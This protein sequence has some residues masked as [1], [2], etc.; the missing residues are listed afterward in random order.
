MRLM[1]NIL[2]IILFVLAL[3]SALGQSVFHETFDQ[4]S[5][6][7]SENVFDIYKDSKGYIWCTTDEGL[8]RFN[9]KQFIAFE[10]PENL[11]LAGSNIKEDVFGRIWYQTFDG[12]FLYVSNNQLH[13]LPFLETS[14][15]KPY[16]IN[17]TH[18]FC[19][20]DKG[21]E[22]I[23]LK[24]L[25]PTL[26]I[27]G[28]GFEYCHLLNGTI[29]YGN[30]TIRQYNLKTK[31]EDLLLV[32]DA[33][34][35]SLITFS[36]NGQ[37]ILADRNNSRV[38]LIRI[39]A[40]GNIHKHQLT[41][42][43]TIQNL[44]VLE[45][46]HWIFTTNGIY[47]FDHTFQPSTNCHFLKD[48]NV[49]SFTKDKNDHLWVGSPNKG[50]F[51][52]KDLHSYEATLKDD[53]FSSL[54][55]KEGIVYTGTK[56]GKIYNH[57]KD[58]SP[59]LYYS[60][61]ENNHILFMDFNSYSDWNFFTGNGLYIM[62]HRTGKV[63]EN[64]ISVK[65]ICKIDEH[66]LG[67]SAT[68]FTGQAS[69]MDLIYNK[70]LQLKAI[71][72]LRAKSCAY[73]PINNELYSA[74]NKG[75]FCITSSHQNKRILFQQQNLLAKDLVYFNGKIIGVTNSGQLFS[76][77]NQRVTL[78]NRAIQIQGIKI[79]GNTCFLSSK[80][81]IYSM[82]DHQLIKLN[83]LNKSDRI[84]DFEIIGNHIY[85]LTNQK[86]IR[87]RMKNDRKNKEIPK[88]YVHQVSFNNDI[89]PVNHWKSISYNNNS[90]RLSIEIVN[91][92][93]LNE[94]E[95]YYIVNNRKYSFQEN[96]QFITLPELSPG[97]YTITLQVVHRNTRKVISQTKLP[98]FIIIPPYW[99]R[100]WFIV[101][102]F[103]VVLLLLISLYRIRLKR[104]NEK[105]QKKLAKLTLENNLKESRL[106]LIKS[107]MNPHFFFNAIN[108]IQSFIFTNETKEASLYLSKLSRLTRKILEFSD[109]N[110]ISLQEEI[111]ALQLY[112]ELQQMRFTDLEFKII[113]EGIDS[114][115]SIQ[116]PTML[117]Q[118]YVE[119][120]ILHGLSHS[121]RK[122]ELTVTVQLTTSRI[123]I[124][125]IEDNGIGRKKSQEINEKNA[126]KSPSF[127]TKA[128]LERIQ[129][130]N[131]KHYHIRID[132]KDLG[133]GTIT[134]TGTR[135][136]ITIELK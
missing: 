107:Q 33:Q 73:D 135:V 123:L 101:G 25:K 50:I 62:N 6:L 103:V 119:N 28:K 76:I 92:D 29:L 61:K 87:L 12:Y 133:D 110:S 18:L 52:I 136:T 57:R 3:P 20:T 82:Q 97:K 26:L 81:A 21:I 27:A 130:L 88:I 100:A 96:N 38:P 80:N 60:T 55:Q 93:Y 86:L 66:N 102:I 45:N 36:G 23:D 118:P 115:E 58:L 30:N 129:L 90:I 70:D 120:A 125:K 39:D 79:N 49:S 40:K 54:S 134:Q 77:K 35:I 1:L 2:L 121:T 56:S 15:F 63:H 67:F 4:K 99:Q 89:I 68:G 108:S 106:Q 32:T 126:G 44:Y 51:L 24:T 47:C 91:F 22:Q 111:D 127:A 8:L 104:L 31:K 41:L 94:Y 9:G 72:Q 34:Y 84:I 128:N 11:S 43:E 78:L 16:G 83:S 122:K 124:V 113:N 69:I 117:F 131:K 17:K 116:I 37:F 98:E 42:D 105:N 14:G 112:L 74:T 64:P 71:Y 95:F 65:D 10:N 109:V 7:P 48:K 5:G 85:I 114:P 46:E 19:V 59:V 53:E 13:S 75:L 132:Y